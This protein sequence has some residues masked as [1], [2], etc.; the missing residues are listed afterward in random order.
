MKGKFQEYALQTEMFSAIAHFY[1]GFQ[2]PATINESRLGC[3]GIET[4]AAV[5][6]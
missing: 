4:I 1:A 3:R 2:I 6:R 5:G